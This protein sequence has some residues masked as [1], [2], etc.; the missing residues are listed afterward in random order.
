MDVFALHTYWS[1]DDLFHDDATFSSKSKGVLDLRRDG[2]EN[3]A[4]NCKFK[5]VRLFVIVS[6]CLTFER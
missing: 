3:V 2:K 5:F 6:I 1:N 4:Q